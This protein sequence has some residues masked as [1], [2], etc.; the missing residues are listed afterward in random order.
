MLDF[1]SDFVDQ[2]FM[3]S[4]IADVFDIFRYDDTAGQYLTNNWDDWLKMCVFNVFSTF[5]NS[6]YVYKP[7]YGT[8]WENI[9]RRMLQ[10]LPI[11]NYLNPYRYDP[12]TGNKRIKY[13]R[14]W[15]HDIAIDLINKMLPVHFTRDHASDAEKAALALGVRKKELTGRYDDVGNLTAVQISKLNEYYGKLNS[16]ELSLLM[17]D[18]KYYKVFNSQKNRYETLRYSRMTSE[19][20]KNVIERIMNDNAK[21]AKVYVLTSNGYKY[22]TDESELRYL[23]SLGIKNVYIKNNKKNGFIK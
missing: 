5:A 10:W 20:K 14:F 7:Q 3:E 2:M 23:K 17:G 22:Y 12:Y 15:L 18:K 16:N 21:T 8:G 9:G 11:A 19:Q 13:S 4:T 6:T 1:I